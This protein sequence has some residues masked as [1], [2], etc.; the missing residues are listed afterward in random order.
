MFRFQAE[1]AATTWPG[2]S[3]WACSL[4]GSRTTETT[5]WYPPKTSTFATS[6]RRRSAS[7]IGF[8]AS[9]RTI[10]RSR[11]E[12]SFGERARTRTA[13]VADDTL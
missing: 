11:P 7:L 13:G 12:P 8:C 1:S 3:R 6:G 10:E 4:S 2:L 5:G 9:W